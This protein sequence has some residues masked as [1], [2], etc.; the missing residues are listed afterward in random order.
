MDNIPIDQEKEAGSR[1]GIWEKFEGWWEKSAGRPIR[2]SDKIVAAVLLI[3][4]L[5]LFYVVLDANKYRA[6]VRV[7][8]GESAVGVNPTSESLDFGDLA[9]GTSA[10]RRVALKNGTP[11]PMFVAV[12]KV[13]SISDLMDL[14]K[15]F[16]KLRPHDST[17]IEFSLYVPA[18]GETGKKYTGRVFL[19]KIPTFGL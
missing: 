3:I 19:F 5:F 6:L 14:D 15:N 16:F 4:F 8:E 1:K 7:I 11:M 17:K 12:W 13:G 10:V 2:R 18:S 9:R